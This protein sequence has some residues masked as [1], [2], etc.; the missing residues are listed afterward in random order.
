MNRRMRSLISTAFAA[1]LALCVPMSA[2]PGAVQ[3]QARIGAPAAAE[4]AA[5]YPA[6]TAYPGGTMRLSIDATDTVRGLYRVRQ[7]IPVSPGTERI[8]LLYPQWL[9]GHHAPRGPIAELVDLRFTADG[10]PVSWKRDPLEVYAF[11]LEL[12]AGTREVTARFIHTSPLRPVEGRVTMTPEMLN[13]QWEKMS[14]YPAGHYVRR[15]RVRPE[16]TLPSGWTAATAL[17]GMSRSGDRVSWAETDFE[18]LVDSPIFAGA[19][20]RQWDLGHSARLD[21]VADLPGYLALGEDR[22]AR[23]SALF[24][25]AKEAFGAP[26]FDRYNFLVALSTRIGGIG[27]EHLSSSENQLEPGN[28]VE[29]DKFDWDRNVLAHELVHAWNGKYRRP[30]R[31]WTPDYRQPMLADMLWIY[32]GQTQFWGWVLAARSGVQDKATV[33]GMMAQAAGYLSEQPGRGWRSLADTTNDPVLAARKAKPYSSLARAEDYYN[34]GA[35]LWLEA[36]QVIRRGTGGARGLDDFARIFFSYRGGEERVRLY[37]F[38]DVVAALNE[39]YPHD[40]ARFLR[41][42]VDETGRPAPLAGIEAAGYRLVWKDEPNPYTRARMDY[43]RELNLYFSLGLT[44]DQEG[45]VSGVRW[46]G[47]A[48]KAGLV[49]GAKIVAIDQTAFSMAWLSQAIRRARVDGQ[50]IELLVRRGDRFDTVRITYRD[51]LRWPWL[52][53]GLERGLEPA[54]REPE[55]SG[56]AALDQLLTARRAGAS[57]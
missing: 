49:G 15:I 56:G 53:R 8:T 21:A 44:V 35:F 22:Q 36:D 26:P 57:Q 31:L 55:G 37:R 1:A 42:R 28:F 38:E 17:P 25:E 19:Y 48:F 52:E 10:K 45:A 39:V 54:G 5:N 13:L 32:E 20:F 6:D 16:V 40:W 7:I 33:L 18:T 4:D 9:P 46:D 29:W 41:D 34:E 43:Y 3:A 14:L 47:P 11:H 51:G 23:L 27:L 30:E 12:P 50:P 2:T 24:A